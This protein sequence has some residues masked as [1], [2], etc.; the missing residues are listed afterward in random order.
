MSRALTLVTR[1]AGLAL[2]AIRA[3]PL[4]SALTAFGILVGVLAVTLVVSLS[5]GASRVVA[6]ALQTMGASSLTIAPRP[7][8]RSG[9]RDDDRPS[10]LDEDD[11]RALPVEAPAVE[12][13]APVVT[14]LQRVVS[15]DRNVATTLVGTTTDFFAVRAWSLTRGEIWG[16]R[17]EAEA[18]RVCIL[19]RTVADE[20][21]GP[22][23]P[24]GRTLRVERFTFRVVGVL[25]KKGQSP[26]GGDQ[27]DVVVLP[28][29][30]ARAKFMP[31]PTARVH[32]VL[33]SA[34]DTTLVDAARA[35][36]AEVLRQRHRL[37]DGAPDDFEI[38]GQDDFRKTESAVLGVLG[39]LLLGVAAVSLVVGGIGV[40]NIML[41]SV[42]ERTREIGIR[43]AIGARAQDILVEFLVEAVV[44][45][46]LGGLAGAVAAA[47]GVVGLG[48][49]LD[50]PM[51]L[52]PVALGVALATSTLIGLVFG[53]FPARSAARK[54]P[55]EAL[56]VD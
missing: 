11:A 23:D 14:I 15:E 19:G 16:A 33:V 8:S 40:M 32:R 7:S 52:S 27:D 50:L 9:V 17:A 35:E 36:V 4:R 2:S 48:R 42:T 41:V 10:V 24:V 43:L 13:A 3:R 55:I 38:R 6:S 18:A 51:T 22:E 54:D 39:A 20:L 44:L 29:T 53:F 37:P 46:L 25:E 30:T 26:F 45:T 1:S 28:L 5:E 49:A 12:R 47:A 31:G 21:F 56:R 34:R